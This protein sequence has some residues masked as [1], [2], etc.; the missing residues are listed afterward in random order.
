[1]EQKLEK[2]FSNVLVTWLNL[3]SLSE[4]EGIEDPDR[5]SFLY[6]ALQLEHCLKDAG[7]ELDMRDFQKELKDLVS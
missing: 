7:F 2:L 6:A 1:M 5:T 4:M 3:K